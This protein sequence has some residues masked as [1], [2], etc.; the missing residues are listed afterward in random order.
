[1]YLYQVDITFYDQIQICCLINLKIN[2]MK[3]LIFLFIMLFSYA[4]FGQ[5]GLKY[6]AIHNGGNWGMNRWNI[7]DSNPPVYPEEYFNWLHDIGVNWVGMSIALHYDNS[8]D[9]I[10]KRKYD[11]QIPTYDDEKLR[12]AIREFKNRGFKVY[13]TLAFESKEA[14]TAEFPV[15]RWQLGDPEAHIYN[16]GIYFDNWPWAIT[17]PLHH[18]FV[19]SFFDSY[20]NQAVHF[21]QIAN[22]EGVDMYSLGTETDK[23]F[24]TRPGGIG[25][26]DFYINL[27]KMVES[28]RDVYSGMLTY[29]QFYAVLNSPNYFGASCDSLWNDLKLDAVG[30]SC[31]FGLFETIPTQVATM[32][33]LTEIWDK[34]IT[35]YIVPLKNRNPNRPIILTEFGYTNDI[36]SPY[37]SNINEFQPRVYSDIN[38]NGLDD[39]EEVQANIYN[40]FFKTIIEREQI[41]EGAFLWGNEMG[42]AIQYLDW[43]TRIHIGIRDKIAD[44]IVK[45]YYTMVLPE[46]PGLPSGKTELCRNPV[47]TVYSIS[48]APGAT[49][50]IWK[51]YPNEAGIINGNGLEAT[52]D[53]SNN[54]IGKAQITVRGQNENGAGKSSDK[55]TVTIST[56]YGV[57]N[58]DSENQIEIYPNITNGDITVNLKALGEYTVQISNLYG[59][60]IKTFKYQG[61][62]ENMLSLSDLS[63][64]VYFINVKSGKMNNTTK[65]L[66]NK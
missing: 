8:L 31:Y 13:M 58:I 61:L 62:T 35:N 54:F 32:D 46:V 10:V 56:C 51:L 52:I 15:Q 26:N 22:D 55:L 18:Q 38:S 23:L 48:E 30:I 2:S 24:R 36:K 40:S 1:M 12:L 16:P 65:I 53:W 5:A 64:G 41:I 11:A 25:T 43:N 17:H 3:N 39:G 27:K 9:S 49:T 4:V 66:L 50:Y 28:V 60:L 42:T 34:I 57:E 14:E 59:Q 45:H 29:D 33:T 19:K 37:L 6:K 21:A 63:N 20:T 47:N 7:T 44:S